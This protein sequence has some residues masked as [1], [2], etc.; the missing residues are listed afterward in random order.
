MTPFDAPL[1][2][3]SEQARRWLEEELTSQRYHAQPSIIERIREFL[4]D[5]L[6]SAP[7]SGLPS[8]A[9]PIAIGL[10]LAVVGLVLWRVLRREVGRSGGDATGVLDVPDVPAATLRAG[11]RAA[12]AAGD[13]DTAV[14]DG[15]RTIARAAVERVV[16][17]DAP[18][19]TAHEVALALT[20]R[21]PGEQQPLLEAADAF[22]A[23]RYGH[24]PAVEQT[25]RA[26]LDLD[27]RLAAARP[28]RVVAEA[29]LET[30]P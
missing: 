4:D 20:P 18:G 23:V 25:A 14:L 5:L 28:E 29:P 10:V 30:V 21:F 3:T 22:D 9:V 13:W 15:V 1:D 8:V 24:R 12:L 19:R 11:A 26:V 17:D 6:N 2:P 7:S 27:A 16:L